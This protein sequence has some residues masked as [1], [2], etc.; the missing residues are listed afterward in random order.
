MSP[1]DPTTTSVTPETKSQAESLLPHFH[2]TKVLSQDQ[3]GRRLN[4]VGTIHSEQ[5]VLTL[6][7]AAFPSDTPLIEILLHSLTD[8]QNLGANDIYRWYMSNTSLSSSHPNLKVNLIWPC[9]ESHIRKYTTQKLRYVTETPEIYQGYIKPW[10]QRTQRTEKRVGW[11]YNILDG[12]TE[13]EDVVYRS[14]GYG[15]YEDKDQ[16]SDSLGFVLLPDLNWDRR[17]VE[18]LHLLALVERRDLWSLRSLRKRDVQ[19]LRR[20]RREAVRAAT[21]EARR[22]LTKHGEVND[23]ADMDEDQFKCYVHYQPTYYHFHVHV[24]HVM[25]EAGATQATG[26][27]FSLD[28]LIEMLEAM[29]GD[30]DEGLE[31]ISVSY[32]MGEE[33][34]LWTKC[35]APLKIGQLVTLNED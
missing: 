23:G 25:L 28:L 6:E 5:A 30:D 29:G 22:L 20:I 31:K 13:Q 26:K 9:T 16:R 4:L 17:S 15:K 35:F 10:I 33:S 27:A 1:Q 32:T 18:G 8:T 24:V 21:V 3:Q 12:I 34:E 7:R 19:W 11:I 2:L 14:E